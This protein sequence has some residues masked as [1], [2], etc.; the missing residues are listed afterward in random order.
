MRYMEYCA[1][2]LSE[3]VRC[4]SFVEALMIDASL[5]SYASRLL[6]F[7]IGSV[8]RSGSPYNTV[9]DEFRATCAASGMAGPHW[10]VQFEC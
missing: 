9:I 8:I 3:C 2:P 7:E 4:T 1:L 6:T 5:S 10:V